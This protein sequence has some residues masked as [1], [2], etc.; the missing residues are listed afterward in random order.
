MAVVTKVSFI[1]D[2]WCRVRLKDEY[3][4]LREGGKDKKY[5]QHP[6]HHITNNVNNDKNLHLFLKSFQ[7]QEKE[8]L[9]E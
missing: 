7:E 6:P 9:N 1:S 2:H 4:Q 3:Q 8:Q 5:V